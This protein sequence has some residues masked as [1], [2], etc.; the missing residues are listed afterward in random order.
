MRTIIALSFLALSAAQSQARW[1]GKVDLTIGGPNEVRD[2][3]MFGYVSGLNFDS[4]GRIV[5]AEPR[6]NQVRVF[7]STGKHLYSF[8]RK[9]AGP[10]DMNGPCCMA[11]DASGRLWVRDF[12]GQRHSI[13]SIADTAAKYVSSWLVQGNGPGDRLNWD[14][15][16]NLMYQRT[17]SFGGPMHTIRYHADSMGK[18]TRRDTLR[19]A[20]V[21]SAARVSVKQQSG[22]GVATYW[23]DVPF[24]SRLLRAEGPGGQLV[25]A[26]SGTYEV[27]WLDPDLRPLRTL[28]AEF[29]PPAVTAAEVQIARDSITEFAKKMK[30]DVDVDAVK[31]PKRKA[32]IASLMFDLDGRLW[33]ERSAVQG[34][35]READVY[36]LEGKLIA[37]ASWPADVV[38][39]YGAIRGMTAL[40]VRFDDADVPSVVRIRFSR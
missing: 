5:V 19:D 25:E 16:G 4:K 36:D 23:V 3:F 8:G 38:L 34:M 39:R 26:I 13:F 6:E 18:I 30:A 12:Y 7:S 37:R 35:P 1:T 15:R 33:V 21:D 10:G 29:E 11:F 24:T 22:G 2:A 20:P 27:V 40:G 28:K 14:A 32:A 17:E 31:I 9:G